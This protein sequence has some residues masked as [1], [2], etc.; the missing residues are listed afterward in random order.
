MI[1]NR[2]CDFAPAL[3]IPV[4]ASDPAT[5]R[6]LVKGMIYYN[7]ASSKFR[8][9]SGAAWADLEGGTGATT[10][11][12]LTD[13]PASI[14]VGDANKFVRVNAAGDALEFDALTGDVTIAA[15]GTT[16][17]AAGV[18]I[19]ADIKSDAAIA[20]SKIALAEGS[21]MVGNSSTVGVA[22]D[23]KTDKYMLIGNGTTLTSV[24]I[25]G[26]IAIT[27]LGVVTV[28]DLTIASEAQGDVLYFDGTN[29]VRLAP[30]TSGK[31]LKTQGA[32][33]NP[34]WDTPSVGSAD[35]LL[36]PFTVEGGT[37]DPSTTVTAQTS[38]AAALTIPNLAGVAQE[39]V[40]TKHAQTLEGKTLTTP[41]F[42]DTGYIADSNGNEL[43]MFGV[44]GSATTYLKITNAINAGGVTVAS[45]GGAAAEDLL[46][47]AKG[48]GVVKAD[49]VEIVTLSGSQALTN[50]TLTAP[51]FVNTGYIADSN[52]NELIMFGVTASATTYLKVTNA[53]N[54]GG[55][56]VE[57]AGGGTDENLL[58]VAKGSG[59]V[60]ADGVEVVTLSDTQT[61]TNKR[62]TSPK[63]NEDVAV[64]STA[65]ELNVLDGISSNVNDLNILS[66]LAAGGLS[67]SEVDILNGAT[68]STAE[69]N[70]LDGVTASY[71]E[72]NL[73]DGATAGTSV[74]SKVLV[75][76]A[77]KNIDTIVIA[78]SGLKLG[79]GAG[80]AVTSTA[81]ELNYLDTSSP[82]VAVASKALVLGTDKNVDELHIAEGKLYLGA[83]AGTAVSSTAV[84]LNKLDGVVAGTVSASLAIV[85][86][87]N[88]RIDTLVIADGGLYLGT[89]AGTQVT[90]TASELSTKTLICEIDDISA[91]NVAYVVSPYAGTL[92]KVYTVIHGAITVASETLTANVNG[93]SDVTNQITIDQASSAAGIID[94]CDPGD[95]KTVAVGNYIKLT[96]AGASTGPCKATVIFVIT[97]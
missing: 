26:D 49:G 19:N 79:A 87:S 7:S 2:N 55:V 54:A 81:S 90:A 39:W 5:A 41:K 38:S 58:L 25:S 82:G 68:L 76:G 57:V 80:T 46:L 14:V 67:G 61:L 47:V 88:K 13:T 93:G 63:V 92:S 15:D 96:S 35:K 1:K 91:G 16:A 23:T 3:E 85:V 4:A 97:L 43:L 75:L 21:L 94:S 69:L 34:I 17:I 30:G 86:D 24:A 52:A 59:V 72:L 89:A 27:N 60:K 71:D 28:T 32:S 11:V 64:T 31:Y 40:F 95:N 29:W 50:K 20:V 56:T 9:Y 51:K 36:S 45:A 44:T 10:F 84:E 8:K 77:N 33:S 65:T 53:I 62:L 70:I 78:D 73:L 83:G 42:V 37:Y 66:G 12:G 48:T 22:L 18:I 6:N 74:A